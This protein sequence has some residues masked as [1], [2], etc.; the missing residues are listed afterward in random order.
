[1]AVKVNPLDSIRGGPWLIVLRQGFALRLVPQSG[2]TLQPYQKD[3]IRQRIEIDGVVPG[4]ASSVRMRWKASYMIKG[5][6]QQEQG[7]VPAFGIV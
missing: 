7:D 2:R 6:L 1:M 3:G 5:E 4:Q